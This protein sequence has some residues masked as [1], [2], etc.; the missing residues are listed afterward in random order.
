[1]ARRKCTQRQR[2][3][4]LVFI[5]TAVLF[6]TIPPL[7]SQA[8]TGEFDYYTPQR[9][10]YAIV[11]P[12]AGRCIITQNAVYATN[13]ADQPIQVYGTADCNTLLGTVGSGDTFQGAFNSIRATS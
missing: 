13:G 5:G 7:S 2:R 10:Q 8:A 4:I 1:M 9:A 11:N 3:G 6:A 12:A